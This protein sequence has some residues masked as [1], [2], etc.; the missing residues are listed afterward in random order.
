MTPNKLVVGLGN[1]GHNYEKTRHNVGFTAIDY[2]ATQMNIHINE[3]RFNSIVG[4]SD[5][6]I[7][8]KPQTFI[9]LSGTSIIEA[10]N[11][12]NIHSEDIIVI[13]DDIFIET[14]SI[15][16][17]RNGDKCSH[18][19]IKNIVEV[20]GTDNFPRI[21]IGTGFISDSIPMFDY[22][23]SNLSEN[24]VNKISS[25][26]EDVYGATKLILNNEID[27]AMNLFN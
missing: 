14:G 22:V 4:Y 18:N 15:R 12:Y 10:M 7:L 21:K 1:P 13:H 26:F 9:N 19:G 20:L 11:L 27:K 16:I 25:R 5:G 8:M 24:E 17:K 23:L 2:I 3:L 6:I